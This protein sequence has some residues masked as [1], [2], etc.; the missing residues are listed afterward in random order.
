MGTVDSFGLFVD[1]C[2]QQ[3]LSANKVTI[4]A[5]SKDIHLP[6]F[7][8]A[9]RL[10]ID[11]GIDQERDLLGELLIIAQLMIT[12]G[13]AKESEKFERSD[14]DTVGNAI[15]LAAQNTLDDDRD[16]TLTEDIVNA[17]NE[18]ADSN[19]LMGSEKERIR[20]MSGEYL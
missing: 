13:E 11:K 2:K 9:T 16:T 12:G 10:I 1:H 20:K 18:L 3:G 17:L 7:A 4:K 15:Q 6:P 5:N 14:W 8:N 19:D